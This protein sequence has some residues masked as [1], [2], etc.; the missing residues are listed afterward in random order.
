[1]QLQ[2]SAQAGTASGPV[3]AAAGY[4]RAQAIVAS[5]PDGGRL[6]DLTDAGLQDQV[7]HHSE[8]LFRLSFEHAPF[9]M[10]LI[11]LEGRYERVNPA[12]CALTG[13]TATELVHLTIG[14]ITH[15]DDVAGDLAAVAALVAG[16]RDSV[17][18]E[19][20]YVTAAGDCV[21]AAKSATL[22]R[23]QDGTPWYIISQLEDISARKTHEHALLEEHRRLRQAESIGRVGSW[24]WDVTTGVTTWSA[25]LFA[26]IG[27]D[28][29]TFTGDLDESLRYT[30]TDDIATV[31]AAF[32]TCA[33]TGQAQ[34]LR[35]RIN[36]A[37]DGAC[38]WLDARGAAVCENGRVVRIVGVVADVTEQVETEQLAA[39]ARSFR[40]AIMTALPDIIFAWDLASQSVVWSSRSTITEL[41]YTDEQAQDMAG[42][43]VSRL[44][45]AE[46]KAQY[47]AAW[48]AARDA[49]T[50][51]A[52]EL[53]LPLLHADGTRRWYTRRIA[54]LHRDE[55]G[56]VTQVV[57]VLRDTTAA[58]DAQDALRE[59]E[60][61]FR[62]LADNV[63]DGFTL[64][65][66]EPDEFLYISPGFEK[67]FGYNPATADET[68]LQTLDRIHPDD[69]ER[70]MSDYWAV[71]QAG[72]PVRHE[73]R[74][75]RADGQIRWIRAT[76]SPVAAGVGEPRRSAAV[77]TDITD[78]RQAEA[79]LALAQKAEAAS[80]A[81]NEFLGRMSHELRTPMNA[82]LGFAQLIELDASPGPQQEAVQHI[83]RG[84]RHLI[85]LIDDVLDIANIEGDRLEL[86]LEPVLLSEVL[87]ETTALMSP[88]AASAKVQVELIN[89]ADADG[90]L[91]VFADA[92]RL[93]QVLLNLLS[94]AIKYS[95]PGGRVE[96]RCELT[97]ASP[98]SDPTKEYAPHV[99]VVVTDTGLGIRA[100]H[101]PRLFTPFDRLGVQAHGIDG[102]GVGLA[103][104][105]RLMA[106]MG[107]GLR[108]TSQYGV[109]SSFTASLALSQPAD[110][111]STTASGSTAPPAATTEL[112]SKTLL[113][114]EDV[115]S[116]VTLMESLIKRRPGWRMAVAG[117]GRLGQEL[118]ST[119]KPDLVLLDMNLPDLAG[120]EVLRHLR[121]DPSTASLPIV[122][123]SADA[124]PRQIERLMAAG[125]DGYLTKPIEV[126]EI[127]RLLETYDPNKAD[128]NDANTAA[129]A[130]TG[131]ADTDGPGRPPV[132]ASPP[133]H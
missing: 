103:L 79:A 20:R 130:D 109:G 56:M 70:F 46:A 118:A 114:I 33:R 97:E 35:Y 80:A 40:Q 72:R 39:A 75:V 101:L 105:R 26:L 11:S 43:L 32:D 42:H 22:M 86:D 10:A 77:I 59:S 69:R 126:G 7:V 88:L 116:N 82:I 78:S 48:I 124:N 96:I 50:D 61:K 68:P 117:H 49:A 36:R 54:P 94:N 31:R 28:P 104:S 71:C 133:Q 129:T 23:R 27:V 2:G 16:E 111:P 92:R 58:K 107:G 112:T 41:G 125:A 63:E 17:V 55:N 73:Y 29:A 106:M 37:D 47:D 57:G 44:V 84:G 127:L 6:Q 38:R 85:S 87:R 115:S 62:Q 110:S 25:G 90:E 18:L 102:T 53:D 91:R 4:D 21:W 24:E 76:S 9:P 51:D 74:I 120:D 81:K 66:W 34:R 119:A 8:E 98:D 5:V 95:H 3:S 93:R 121:S 1:M 67:I 131:S 100:E 52:V 132:G 64:R 113:Y 12:M 30:H 60:A 45:P 83:L 108:A 89:T 15:P 122:I 65:T 128:P 14:D 99:D 123:L 13:Y 19:K